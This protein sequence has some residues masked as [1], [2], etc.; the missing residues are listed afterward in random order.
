MDIENI[1]DLIHTLSQ[2][3]DRVPETRRR[4]VKLPRSHERTAE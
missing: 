4:V 3:V 2:A 1:K